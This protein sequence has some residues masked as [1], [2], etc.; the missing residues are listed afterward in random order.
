M[1]PVEQDE[2]FWLLREALSSYASDPDDPPVDD[3]DVIQAAV[4]LVLRGA[5][6]LEL[7]LIKRA[8]S[9]RDPW[10]GH[11]AGAGGRREHADGSLRTTAA[12]ETREETGVE[13]GEGAALLGALDAVSPS[14]IKL[15]RLTIA[16]YVFGVRQHVEARVA[17][18][19]VASV[20][21]VGVEGLRSEGAR[22]EVEIDLPWGT[23]SF[24]CFYVD[25]EAVWGLTSRILTQFLER[26]PD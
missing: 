17:S 8:K 18:A 22:K 9:E 16:P 21:W 13:L 25:G 10:S 4:S 14:N 11:M 1:N 5:D 26:Y 7:L 2:R 6:D 23:R 15:P 12:R 24:P 3:D 20:H 19:E